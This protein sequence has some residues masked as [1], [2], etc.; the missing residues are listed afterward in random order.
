MNGSQANRKGNHAL[1]RR[2]PVCKKLRKFHEPNGR[3]GGEPHPRRRPWKL[4]D[5]VWICG[6]C[7]GTAPGTAA[8]SHAEP[9][10]TT[11]AMQRELGKVVALYA[12]YLCHGELR[13]AIRLGAPNA[14]EGRCVLCDSPM[15]V[16]C[17]I[18]SPLGSKK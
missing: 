3:V 12:K 9:P 6:W 8:A 14:L 17:K 7:T 10:M 1:R 16:Y 11:G 18:C 5:N 15:H 4:V 13:A 2:C